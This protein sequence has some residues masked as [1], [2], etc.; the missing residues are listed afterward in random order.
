MHRRIASEIA[1]IEK[2]Y[3]NPLGEEVIFELLTNFKYV[4]PAGSP[5][6][7]IG[8]PFQTSSLSNCFVIGNSGASDSYGGIMKVD[9]EQVQLMKR[10]RRSRP[11]SYQTYRQP[12]EKYCTHLYRCG[13]IHGKIFK[14]YQRSGSG[15]KKRSSYAVH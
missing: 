11:E 6:A 3:P 2:K 1:R 13:S 10:R 15:W 8:N 7:G 9:Q 12:G 14:L 5:M 4:I